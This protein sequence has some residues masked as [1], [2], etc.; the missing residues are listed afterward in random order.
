MAI[1]A[2]SDPVVTARDSSALPEPEGKSENRKCIE[3][4][5]PLVSFPDG[6]LW[7]WSAVAGSWMVLFVIFGSLC[8]YNRLGRLF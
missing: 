6:G 7:G 5:S 3:D 1:D 2:I 4:L 8:T